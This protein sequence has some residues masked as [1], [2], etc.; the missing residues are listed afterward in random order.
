[1]FPGQLQVLALPQQQME[2]V[3]VPLG[4]V[5]SPSPSRSLPTY[6]IEPSMCVKCGA[7]I[8]VYAPAS[9]DSGEW[10]CNF[11]L[12]LNRPGSAAMAPGFG[13]SGGL[14]GSSLATSPMFAAAPGLQQQQ[15]DAFVTPPAMASLGASYS[16]PLSGS[17]SGNLSS[18]GSGT[19]APATPLAPQQPRL[20]HEAV[21]YI[22]PAA[23]AAEPSNQ[24]GPPNGNAAATA[25][26][27]DSSSGPWV[28][29]AAGGAAAGVTVLVVDLV[30][31]PSELATVREALLSAAAAL[32]ATARVAL[33]AAGTTVVQAYRLAGHGRWRVP[34]GSSNGAV[35]EDDSPPLAAAC[36]VLPGDVEGAEVDLLSALRPGVHVAPAG[37]CREALAAA[38]WSLR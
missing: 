9:G 24:Q 4:A 20:Q 25:A 30:A 32:P 35:D 34:V 21:D 1:M 37:E 26:A 16:G 5:L 7:F 12:H 11:C 19:S 27:A 36:D 8:N 33:V 13:G 23:A 22:T 29:P 28:V 38:L 15:Q 18:A 10:H 14:S 2:L 31:T 6:P 17:A 3:G